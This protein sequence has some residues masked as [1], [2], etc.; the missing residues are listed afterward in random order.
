MPY[1]HEH[2]DWPHFTWRE[3]DL[4][5]VLPNVRHRQGRLLGKMEGLGFR[6]RN[7]ASLMNLTSEVI[8]SSAIEGTVF[9]PA[10]VRSS[11]A[12]RM[13]LPG[14][15]EARS[16]HDVEGAVEMMLDAT[17]KFAEP[18]TADRLLGWQSS[19]FPAG[20]SGLHRVLV[21]RWRTPEMDPM[22][23]VSGPMS[24]E[25]VRKKNIHFEAPT[26]DRLPR[27][28]RAFL[29]WFEGQNAID[30]ILRAAVAHL[31][32]VTIH[33]F[34]DGNG[35][36]SRAIADMALARADG[37][38]LQFYSMSTQIEAE[39]KQYYDNLE[40]TQT[41]GMDITP[42]LI[43]FL[44]CLDRALVRADE[45]LAGILQK[46]AMWE[47][48]NAGVPVNDRQRLVLNALLDRNEQEI[49]TSRY[50]KLARCSLD[51]A[52]RDIKSLVDTGVVVAGAGGGRSTKY[53]L[54][55]V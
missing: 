40:Q 27:E 21:G 53:Q 16:S 11:I 43:W 46:S 9:D 5:P 44:R 4:L 17:Q 48:I 10:S 28:V 32:F 25:R 12:R 7:E 20:R 2:P 54:K 39:K 13:G 45:S 3:A 26:A 1:I 30:P 42:W 49:S 6:F 52:L 22:Q 34:E 8:K 18:L 36:V 24:R 31:W 33:P 55:A 50:A 19:L 14:G 23:V 37:S 15:R 47:R 41:G 38:A 51:T 35:R 29:Q